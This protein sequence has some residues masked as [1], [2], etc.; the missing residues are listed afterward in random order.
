MRDRRS[1]P[2]SKAASVP[3]LASILALVLATALPAQQSDDETDAEAGTEEPQL[4]RQEEILVED[5]LPYLPESNTITTKLPLPLA[6]TP[7]SVAV[8]TAPILAEQNATVLGDALENV[9]GLNVQTGNG[10]YDFFVVRGLDSVSSGMIL[11][12]GA[13]EPES[14]F[15]QLYNVDRVEVLKGPSSFL[16]GGSPLAGTVNL[17]RK[18]PLPGRFAR[19]A[20]SGGSHGTGEAVVDWNSARGDGSLAFRLNTLYRRSDGYRDDKDS[21]V[22]AVNPTLTWTPDERTRLNLSLEHLSSEYSP[23]AGLP[24][25]GGR[26]L[27]DVPR[28]RSYQSPFDRSDQDIDRFQAD[29]ERRVSTRGTLRAKLYYRRL[30]W[31]SDGTLFNGVF[32][33]A[34]GELA[35]SRFLGVLDDRQQFVGT[36]LEYVL[37]AATGGITHNVL[38]GLELSQ[39]GD[40]FTF[41]PQLLPDISLFDPVETATRP[42]F[43]I[44]GQ[45]L[46]AD[47]ETRVVA[48][49]LVDQ[50]G[51]GDRLQVLLGARWDN[52][53]FEEKL[54]DTSRH[55]NQLNP[56]VGVLFQATEAVAV[57]AN[58][59]TAFAAPSSFGIEPDRVPEESTQ[60]ELGVK[61]RFGKRVDANLALFQLERDNI[62]IPDELG[63]TR[64]VGDQRARGLE[65][66]VSTELAR[67]TR[68][69]LVYA[70]TDGELTRYQELVQTAAFPPAFVTIDRSGNTPAFTPEHLLNA[71]LSRHYDNGFGFGVGGRYVSDQFIAEDN[72]FSIDDYWTLDASLFYRFDD[73]RLALFLENLTGEEYLTRGFGANSVI[74]APEATAEI[75]LGYVF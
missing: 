28:R 68:L 60:Y 43:P 69:L 53:D 35:V 24:L 23:D 70:F 52:A 33:S 37:E 62:P 41:V 42:L 51:L 25:V 74:P 4:H 75:S 39:L 54:L 36:Q 57:Y 20:L 14:S 15:Y 19:V 61:S 40:E 6:E 3:L 34:G 27:P 73:W 31:Q 50:I 21:R 67:R 29:F 12:D 9:S 44:P 11:T 66:E 71:W 18:Q 59:G 10:V 5:T 26:Q 58:F 47:A 55:D 56:L 32:P 38:F 63:I 2:M 72:V 16:Y 30:D 49:Y 7:A 17:V 65:V 22:A 48:P 13:P 46:G 45:S 1:I 8:I 64:Q